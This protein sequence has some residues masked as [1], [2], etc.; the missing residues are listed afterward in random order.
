M[1]FDLGVDV[2]RALNLQRYVSKNEKHDLGAK[3]GSFDFMRTDLI[4]VG[5]ATS[6]RSGNKGGPGIE[7]KFLV[8]NNKSN[9]TTN[10]YVSCKCRD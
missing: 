10:I 8:L 9:E 4:Y 3:L 5:F 6:V 1:S 7:P 2:V